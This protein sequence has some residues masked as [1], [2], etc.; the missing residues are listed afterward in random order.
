MSIDRILSPS[1]MR[2]RAKSEAARFAAAS[3]A[4]PAIVR[5][6]NQRHRLHQIARF[7]ELLEAHRRGWFDGLS[8]DDQFR[9]ARDCYA[10]RTDPRPDIQRDYDDDRETCGGPG[11]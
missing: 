3:A 2:Q 7:R 6:M 5:D 9:L 4:M 8:E 1:E 10:L 11:A